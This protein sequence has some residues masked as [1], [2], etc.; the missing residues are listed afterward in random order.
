M[1][2]R[3]AAGQT[4]RGYKFVLVAESEQGVTALV[5]AEND[6]S[7]TSAVTAVRA[8]VGDVF[9][10]SERNGTRTAV[11]GFYIYFYI[12]DKHMP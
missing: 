5:D 11:T 6:V 2:L 10:T 1:E 8:T 3:T 7:A 9:L 12:I 4:V